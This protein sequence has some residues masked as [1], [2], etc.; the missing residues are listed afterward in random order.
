[1]PVSRLPFE[2]IANISSHL[3]PQDKYQCALVCRRWRT[4]FTESLWK[5][6]EIHSEIQLDAICNVLST[7]T[8]TSKSPSHLVQQLFLL[9][10]LGITNS[11]LHLMQQHFCFLDR[12]WIDD[13]SLIIK[14]SVDNMHWELWKHL[15]KLDFHV[16]NTDFTT[17]EVLDT[18]SY[19]PKLTQLSLG[20]QYL[21]TP[22]SFC[23]EDIETIHSHLPLLKK[24]SIKTELQMISVQDMEW[25]ANVK[26]AKS[27]EFL[28]FD[29]SYATSQWI[30]YWA[31]KYPNMGVMKWSAGDR[32]I[33]RPAFEN[34]I[35]KKSFHLKNAFQR[36]EKITI[37]CD[38]DQIR[39][40]ELFLKI[41]LNQSVSVKHFTYSMETIYN[42]EYYTPDVLKTLV[43]P[44]STSLET[45]TLDITANLSDQLDISR[46]LSLY[47]RLVELTL[48]LLSLEL[49]LNVMLDLCPALNRLDVSSNMLSIKPD[50][51]EQLNPH[52]LVFL[53]ISRAKTCATLF[54]YVSW[55]CRRLQTLDLYGLRV[56]GQISPLTGNFRIYMPHS[57]FNVLKL[58]NMHFYRSKNYRSC[59]ERNRIRLVSFAQ[60]C[61]RQKSAGLEPDRNWLMND[62]PKGKADWFYQCFAGNRGFP[63]YTWQKLV[64]QE[65]EY[66]KNYFRTYLYDPLCGSHVLE[67]PM[68]KGCATWRNHG[69]R[70]KWKHDLPLG[71]VNIRCGSA[72]N[73]ILKDQSVFW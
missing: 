31:H 2:I 12:L 7:I 69:N 15:T 22:P 34:T 44:F 48:T 61:P 42:K 37:D 32:D 36:L 4:P 27:L 13:E 35:S 29:S 5:K 43:G 67:D 71:Y 26:P 38:S 47:P 70:D 41:L 11:Q 33:E 53:R 72:K 40:Q 6:V 59:T 20:E 28:E 51:S 52:N 66:T 55:R 39:V 62:P 57:H 46:A 21:F 1:M 10:Y 18:L 19:L 68:C 16:P 25:I 23:L 60:E 49:E 54:N 63:L 8:N 3:N 65:I 64:G 45:L 17:K 9:P 30:Y 24:L 58:E 56:S 73:F 50:T 14:C